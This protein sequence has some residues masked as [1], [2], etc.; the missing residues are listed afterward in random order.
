MAKRLT[1]QKKKFL[2]AWLESGDIREASRIAKY[3]QPSNGYKVLRQENGVYVDETVRQYLAEK[4]GLAPK[5]D[6]RPKIE[7]PSVIP[8][9]VARVINLHATRGPAEVP[10]LAEVR[11]RLW[12]VAGDANTSDGPRVQALSILLKDLKEMEIPEPP[13]AEEVVGILREKLRI[14]NA[15]E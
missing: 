8:Q 13:S 10:T 1:P 4:S 2:D 7:L 9:P 11:A 12:E 3:N 15:N 5:K 14:A 6:P